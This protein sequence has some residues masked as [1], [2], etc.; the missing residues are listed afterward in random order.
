MRGEPINIAAA[1][2]AEAARRDRKDRAR[3]TFYDMLHDEALD[4]GPVFEM[5]D[6]VRG[7]I[8][9]AMRVRVDDEIMRAATSV[10][11]IVLTKQALEAAFAAAGFE[12]EE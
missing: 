12:V 3:E 8:E 5:S 10:S 9:T 6:C 2:A 7:A 1:Q 11:S 4:G